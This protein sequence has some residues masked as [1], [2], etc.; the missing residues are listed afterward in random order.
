MKKE[1]Y[2]DQVIVGVIFES[3]LILDTYNELNCPTAG[4]EFDKFILEITKLFAKDKF[5]YH[6][7][8]G[9]IKFLL[10]NKGNSLPKSSSGSLYT[11]LEDID[12]IISGIEGISQVEL[13]EEDD[14]FIQKVY[15][16]IF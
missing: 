3:K 14:K 11:A 4:D 7:M 16:A 13:S 9:T 5:K 15:Y 1:N 12:N 8:E 2:L 10:G 6:E